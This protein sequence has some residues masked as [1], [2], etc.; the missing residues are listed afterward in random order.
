MASDE[1]GVTPTWVHWQLP[2][3]PLRPRKSL[4][5]SGGFP[6]AWLPAARKRRRL[7]SRLRSPLPQGRK[8]IVM[9]LAPRPPG[10]AQDEEE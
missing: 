8:P 2:P 9:T 4:L 7:S 5:S 10:R 6:S 3:R 1:P